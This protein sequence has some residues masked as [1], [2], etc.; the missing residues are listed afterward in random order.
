M[1]NLSNARHMDV[2]RLAKRLDNIEPFYVVQVITRAIELEAQGK[3]IINLAVGE[4]DFPTPQP[5]VDAAVAALKSDRMRYSPSLG[6]DALRQALSNWY[7]SRYAVDVPA[8]RIAV[9]S[10]ASGALLLTMGMVISEGDEVLMPDP[11]YPCNR[12]FVSSMGGSARLIPVG[13]ETDYQLTSL[14]VEQNWTERT[15]GVMVASPSNPTGTLMDHDELQKIV[16]F[17][18][19]R[20]G[21]VIVDEIYHGLT[22]DGQ[23]RTA[24]DISDDVFVIN[25]FSKYFAMTGWRLG[26]TVMPEGYVEHFE[27]LAQN[28][29][30]S[31]SDVAQR[32][33]LS[34]FDLETIEEAEKNRSRYKE[35][36][37]F[38]LP[39]LRDLGFKIPV[40]PSGAFYI[41]ADC[42]NFTND[43]YSFSHDVLEKAG[44]AI[45]PGLDFGDHRANEHVRFSYP[46][47]IPVLQEGIRRLKEFTSK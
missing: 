36:R 13:A 34:A 29:Y 1:N 5:I 43:S 39:A 20:G 11:S 25:S 17:V 28:L 24:L 7:Q 21:V 14:L 8:E 45:A 38:L 30:I 26:W 46:K 19:G 35:Q 10:G 9:T 32:A 2:A 44:V 12:H 18:R 37:D 31:N 15:V 47:P 22:Y 16:E 23:V 41:Y 42:T 4:P 33:A 3:S 40:E 27:K 6:S